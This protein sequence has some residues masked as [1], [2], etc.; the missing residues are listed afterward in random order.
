VLK[1][2]EIQRKNK[3]NYFSVKNLVRIMVNINKVSDTTEVW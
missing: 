3:Q 1:R 2:K